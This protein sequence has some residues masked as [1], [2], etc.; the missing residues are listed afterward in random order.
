MVEKGGKKPEGQA[1]PLH[2]S[3]KRMR[4]VGVI[5]ADP[6]SA[7]NLALTPTGK[8]RLKQLAELNKLSRSEYL[9]RL[10]ARESEKLELP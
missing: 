1:D 8:E 6:K 10:L 9:E 2:T 5:Y 4:G 3:K 7:V